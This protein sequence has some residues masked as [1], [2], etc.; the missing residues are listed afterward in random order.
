VENVIVCFSRY[1]AFMG[2]AGVY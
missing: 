1:Q 2:G